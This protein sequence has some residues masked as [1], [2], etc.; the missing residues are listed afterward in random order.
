MAWRDINFMDPTVLNPVCEYNS[1][2][3]DGVVARGNAPS[4]QLCSRTFISWISVVQPSLLYLERGN[5]QSLLVNLNLW[6]RKRWIYGGFHGRPLTPFD[7]TG[8]TETS[9]HRSNPATSHSFSRPLPYTPPFSPSFNNSG[10]EGSYM[11]M[12][13]FWSRWLTPEGVGGG[14]DAAVRKVW[15]ASRVTI[16]SR[17]TVSLCVQKHYVTIVY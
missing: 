7:Y 13:A 5:V 17:P 9:N 1:C 8:D 11:K 14:G 3:A 12:S 2:F 10:T 16:P 4:A 6:K 15:E